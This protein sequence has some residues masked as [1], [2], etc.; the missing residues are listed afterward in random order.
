MPLRSTVRLWV[1]NFRETA[2]AD[3]KKPKGRKRSVRISKVLEQVRTSV[4]ISPTRSIRK[5]SANLNITRTSLQ[6]ILSKDLSFHPYKILIT[7]KLEESDLK[8]RKEFAETMLQKLT[9]M[10]FP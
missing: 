5:R 6:R 7:Q 9:R 8:A 1:K 10:R 4:Q 2:S 3:K